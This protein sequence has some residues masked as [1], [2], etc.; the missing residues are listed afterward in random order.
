M[1]LLLLTQVIYGYM[2]VQHGMMWAQSLD[3]VVLQARQAQQAQLV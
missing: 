1:V 2:M 3:Q